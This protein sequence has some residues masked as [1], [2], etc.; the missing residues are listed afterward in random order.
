[1]LKYANTMLEFLLEFEMR[2]PCLSL[3]IDKC[4]LL[5]CYKILF[6]EFVLEYEFFYC[7]YLIVYHILYIIY[8]IYNI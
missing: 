7:F 3:V 8:N 5:I 2:Y 6:Y 1:M 4:C